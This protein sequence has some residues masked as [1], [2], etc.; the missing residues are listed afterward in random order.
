MTEQ[1]QKDQRPAEVAAR[2]AAVQI[3]TESEAVLARANAIV[4]VTNAAEYESA[5]EV[6]RKIAASLREQ[7]TE[8]LEITRPM[9]AAKARIMK[10]FETRMSPLQAVDKL[11]D[12]KLKTFDE[13]QKRLAD[14][15]PQETE[16]W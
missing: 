9:D 15:R 12:R 4:Q 10:L 8:R 11:I 6:L 1:T 2:P 7:Q 5:V 3:L 14:L 16:A 13:E